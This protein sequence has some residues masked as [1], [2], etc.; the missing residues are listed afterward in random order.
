MGKMIRWSM[1]DPAGC[2]QRGQ[3]SLSQLPGILLSFEN[4]AAET[5]RRTGSDHVLYA[6]KIYNAADEELLRLAMKVQ[7][8]TSAYVSF[9]TSNHG[10]ECVVMIMDDGFEINHGYDGWYEMDIFYPDER[11]EKEYQ[12]AKEHLVRLLR[13]KR[14]VEMA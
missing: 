11:S 3:M 12:K 13:K 5:L 1:K 9:E 4:S 2:I 6:V 10:W 8:K 7:E 14:K